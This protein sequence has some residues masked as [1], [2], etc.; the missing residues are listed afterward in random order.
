LAAHSSLGRIFRGTVFGGVKQSGLGVEGGGDI[1]LK[2]F[3]DITT[4][5]IAK[6][7]L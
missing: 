7:G 5:R 4:L 1:G 2:E 3:T 6:K